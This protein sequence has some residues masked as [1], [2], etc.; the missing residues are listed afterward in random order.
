MNF[1]GDVSIKKNEKWAFKKKKKKP[2]APKDPRHGI[3]EEIKKIEVEVDRPAFHLWKKIKD[4]I[5]TL[6][7]YEAIEEN[8]EYK[9][10]HGLLDMTRV[11][12]MMAG[13]SPAKSAIRQS[14]E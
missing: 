12:S 6:T 10:T 1:N 8:E 9:Q 5:Y 13:G 14:I 4:L 3:L 2:R 7:P 11:E